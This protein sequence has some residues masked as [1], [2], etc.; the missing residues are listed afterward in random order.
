[1]SRRLVWLLA[2][3][4]LITLL[5]VQRWLALSDAWQRQEHALAVHARLGAP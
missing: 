4:A 5:V 1:M 2:L 3:D